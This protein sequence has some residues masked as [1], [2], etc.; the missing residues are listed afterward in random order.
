[1]GFFSNLFA[2]KSNAKRASVKGQSYNATIASIPPIQ[3]IR[4]MQITKTIA[5][6]DLGTYPVSGNGPNVLDQLQRAARKRSQAQ[7]STV[8]RDDYGHDAIAPPPMV[9]RFYGQSR[10]T[11]APNQAN[12]SASRPLSLSRSIRSSNSAWSVPEKPSRG[13]TD[14]PP[15]VP[16]IPTHHRRESSIDSFQDKRHSFIDVLDAQGEFSHPNFRSRLSATGAREYDEDVAERNLGDNG[17]NLNSAAT[18][19]YYRL[20][21]SGHLELPTNDR[22]YEE[23]DDDDCAPYPGVPH[24]DSGT[25]RDK[26]SKSNSSVW[27]RSYSGPIGNDLLRTS[28]SRLRE[29][30]SESPTK[31]SLTSL[32]APTLSKAD[33]RRS[34]NAFASPQE[35]EEKSRKPRPLS[36]HPSISSFSYDRPPSPP[37]LLPPQLSPPSAS[38]PPVQRSRP[39]TSEGRSRGRSFGHVDIEPVEEDDEDSAP[40]PTVPSRFRL[41]EHRSTSYLEP[42][43]ELGHHNTHNQRPESYHG[44]LGM[45]LNEM[46]HFSRPTSA[47]SMDKSFNRSRTMT[48]V[49]SQ[50]LDDINEHIPVRTSSLFKAQPCVTPSTMSSG[51]SSNPFPR[52][53]GHHTPST[54]I[55]ASLPPSIKLHSEPEQNKPVEETSYYNAGD[56]EFSD[57]L[58]PSR[59]EIERDLGH[60]FGEGTNLDLYLSDASEDSVDSFV[61]WKEKRRNEEGLLMKDAYGTGAGLPGLF[62]PVPILKAS[63]EPPSLP[64]IPVEPV[65]AKRPKTPKSPI[66]T[67]SNRRPSTRSSKSTPNRSQQRS[68]QSRRSTNTPRHTKASNDQDSDSDWEDEIPSAPTVPG[69]VSLADLGIDIRELGWDQFGLTEADD[70]KVDM[71]TA[72]KLRKAIKAKKQRQKEEEEACAA[73]VEDH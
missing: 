32:K 1:M 20:S 62:E 53:V 57:T 34:F 73:D 19:A 7:L 43:Y 29:K 36:L 33:R 51:F 13:R 42:S 65:V 23:D 35:E 30:R 46:P 24:G 39:R 70:A 17:L 22:E 21:G 58:V 47:S 56:D 40:F 16:S 67:K 50:R 63:V 28:K 68:R 60:P 3:G 26:W 6:K 12:P 31:A 64:E 14:K 49:R 5:N 69:F 44:G 61:A 27:R 2:R 8:S 45:S 25:K 72:I 59:R 10:P 71:Q 37:T 15:P 41:S 18:Q 66:S 4:D 38:P 11:T 48:S 9:P 54:S 55:D 52:S